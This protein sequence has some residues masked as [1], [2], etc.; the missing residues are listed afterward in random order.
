[1]KQLKA[2]LAERLK[3]GLQEAIAYEKGE[4]HLTIRNVWIP[5]P[6][7][8]YSGLEIAALRQKLGLSQD[9]LAKVVAVSVKT[10]RSW[11]QGFRNPSGSAARVLQ[12]L[13]HPEKLGQL[14]HK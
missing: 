9:T 4:G 13:E 6:P 7:Q 2:P 11:E 5:D 10:V 14:V 8:K 1:M 3:K 12:L